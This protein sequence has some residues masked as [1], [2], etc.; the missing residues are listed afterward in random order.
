MI[1]GSENNMRENGLRDGEKYVKIPQYTMKCQLYP[2]K[3]CA[4]KID[5]ILHAVKVAHNAALYDTFTNLANTKETVNKKDGSVVHYPDVRKMAKAD[6]IKSLKKDHPCIGLVPAG[7][8]QGN[9]GIFLNDVKRMLES[10][11]GGEK[12]CKRKGGKKP[13][14]GKKNSEKKNVIRPVETSEPHFYSKKHPRR[15]YTYQQYLS[16]VNTLDNLNVLYVDITKVGIIKAKGWNQRIRFGED[17]DMNFIEYAR[18]NRKKKI[19]VTI[20]KDACDKYWICFKFQNVW[21][22]CKT[23]GNNR[24]G[25]DM[26]VKDLAITSDGEKFDNLKFGGEAKKRITKMNRALSRKQGFANPDFREQ[27]KRNK[28][29][30]PSKKYMR[31]KMELAKSHQKVANKRRFYQHNITA[32]IVSDCDFIGVETLMITNMMRNRHMSAALSDV[33]IGQ[34]LAMLK[35]KAQ[36]QSK[37]VQPIGR[38]TPS[39][40]RC[41]CC[42]YIRPKM[43]LSIREWTCPEC[44]AK[45]DRDINAAKNILQYAEIAFQQETLNNIIEQSID[46]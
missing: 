26:G 19:T 39:T 32:Q 30:N 45:H 1:E 15:S 13:G 5:D 18:M 10:Q 43:T 38:W 35:Y 24:I 31:A 22:P 6:Y 41:N 7:A 25:I 16:F 17:A 9:N 3:T 40:K 20:S 11:V 44:G 14:N 33:S 12:D 37:I 29:L 42:G 4:K 27:Y 8:L 46:C 23:T 2:N 34:F 36:W 21:K 28:S